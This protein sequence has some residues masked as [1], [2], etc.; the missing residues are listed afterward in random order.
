[1]CPE[2]G[3]GQPAT[4]LCEQPGPG[5]AED[6]A[7]A[8]PLSALFLSAIVERAAPMHVADFGALRLGEERFSPGI[9]AA[10][11]TPRRIAGTLH[12]APAAAW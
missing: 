6:P 10:R 11:N 1:M 4:A 8:R 9:D 2:A 3:A 7:G 5:A 12:P